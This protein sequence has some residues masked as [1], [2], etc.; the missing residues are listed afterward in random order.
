LLRKAGK[1]TRDGVKSNMHLVDKVGGTRL[2]QGRVVV[3]VV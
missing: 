3:D 2:P 1:G